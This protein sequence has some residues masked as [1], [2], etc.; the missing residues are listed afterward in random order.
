MDENAIRRIVREELER[1]LHIVQYSPEA[2]SLAFSFFALAA[3]PAVIGLQTAVE[4][5]PVGPH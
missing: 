4:T 5:S 2:D 1:A 3:S